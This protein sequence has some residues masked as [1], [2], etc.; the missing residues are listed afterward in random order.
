[1]TI[2]RLGNP[3]PT[4]PGQYP[5]YARSGWEIPQVS[6]SELRYLLG[7][8]TLELVR[9]R[10]ETVLVARGK[11]DKSPIKIRSLSP[12]YYNCV[13]MIFASRRAFIEIDYIYDILEHD[14]YRGIGRNAVTAGDVVVYKDSGQPTHVALVIET[15]L[16]GS[17]VSIKVLS[18]WGKDGE[19]EHLVENVPPQLGR[20]LE[21]FTERLV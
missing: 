10:T 12:F 6:P 2:L 8:Q 18:K 9:L 5:V 11:S 3:P 19:L 1:M 13:G 7:E 17:S 20:P 21:F 14:G 15:V 4:P 16:V